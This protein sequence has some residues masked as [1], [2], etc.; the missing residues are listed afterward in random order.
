MLKTENIEV[1]Y[2]GIILTL[3]GVSVEVPDGKC[4]AVLGANGAGKTTLLKSISGLIHIDEGEVTRGGIY[5][6]GHRIDRMGPEEIVKLGII[7][8]MEGRQVLEHLS[9]EQNLKVAS[10]MRRDIS[11]IKNDLDMVYGYFSVLE[12]LKGQ[13]AGYLSGGEQQMLVVGR[14]FMAR[15]T[16]MLLDEPSLGLGPLMIREI[17]NIL[18]HLRDEQNIT[19]LL[20]EQNVNAALSIADYGYVME[21]GRMV[22]SGTRSEL[23]KNEDVREFY[24]GLS[25][26]GQRT[27]YRDV[28]HY[29]RRK[30]WLG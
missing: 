20:V 8:V 10:H 29:K 14:A 27:S 21:N 26:S 11:G 17:Y 1:R 3:K 19:L 9:V 16:T 15:P 2:L 6:D 13:S 24:L 30:R 18:R 12:G 28:K 7:Q 25:L 5:Y 22:L 23:L 4:I